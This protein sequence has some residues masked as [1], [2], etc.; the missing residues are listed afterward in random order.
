MTIKNIV[1]VSGKSNKGIEAAVENAVQEVSKLFINVSTIHL[2]DIRVHI[3][4]GKIDLYEVTCD[5]SFSREKTETF[6]S[7]SITG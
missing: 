3:H 1:E 6:Q 7:Q 4:K 2:K 5:L